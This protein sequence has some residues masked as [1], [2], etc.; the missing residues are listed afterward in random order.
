MLV[1]EWD[2]ENKQ[3]T[4]G[5]QQKPKVFPAWLKGWLEGWAGTMVLQH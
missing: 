5:E 4:V 2:S 3:R 1:H